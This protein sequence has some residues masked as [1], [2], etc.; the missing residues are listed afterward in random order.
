MR[1]AFCER[2]GEIAIREVAD[3]TPRAGEA[4]VRVAACGI[5]GSDLHWFGGAGTPPAV[6]PG[7]EIVGEVVALAGGGVAREG[8]AVAVEPLRSCRSCARC[9]RGDY[10]LCDQLRI[11]GVH[12]DGG[13]A[14][15]VRVPIE[16]LYLIPAG[17]SLSDAVL[18]EPL[19]V[20]VHAARLG[21]VVAGSRVVIL[22]AGAIGLLAIVACRR[23]G[24]AEVLVSARH[25]HQRDQA[26]RLGATAV[27]PTDRDGR[28]ALRTAAAV[29][30]VDVVLETVGG[31]APTL[32]QAIH[33]VGPGGTVVVLGLFDVDPPYPALA[34][35]VK[36]ARVVGSIVYNR[37]AA[38]SDF[39][40]ALEF[41]RDEAATLRALVTHRFSLSDAQAA[42]RTAAD[43]STGAIKVA[44]CP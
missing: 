30:D 14:E 3:L 25:A 15:A 43:K 38:G 37:T 19:A 23:L 29:H 32:R 42:F 6:C 36:E 2:A 22:G 11:L 31:S 16:A 40:I 9:R 27:F 24:A 44:I 34:A 10:H 8:D 13:L 20:T 28:G 21:G 7:H 5:C 18:T 33:L 41:L 4:I 1:A 17:L 26:L 12:E 35:L 39:E